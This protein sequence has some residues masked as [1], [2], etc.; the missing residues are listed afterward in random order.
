MF[1]LSAPFHIVYTSFISLHLYT[2]CLHVLILPFSV[3]TKHN[4]PLNINQTTTLILGDQTYL[5]NNMTP[6][7]PNDV[8]FLWF[9]LC[10]SIKSLFSSTLKRAGS[11]HFLWI[12][13]Q[14]KRIL[15]VIIYCQILWYW[16]FIIKNKIV[17]ICI[18]VY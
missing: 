18:I 4:I 8:Y 12:I 16:N 2:I 17:W 14:S 13:I 15:L 1:L 9:F 5:P 7:K 3:P 10:F 11:Y 6:T